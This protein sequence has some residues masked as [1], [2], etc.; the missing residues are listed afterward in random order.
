VSFK[1]KA[2]LTLIGMILIV[3]LGMLAG[4]GWLAQRAFNRAI[5]QNVGV[6]RSATLPDGI[7]VY[8]CGSGSPMPDADRAGPCL[9][10]LAGRDGFVFDAGA[11]SIR[12]LGRMGFPMDRLQGAYLTHLHSDHIDGLGELLLQAWIAGSRATPLPVS[13]P[14]GTEQVVAGLTQAYTIDSGYRI[15]HHGP[16]V[17]RPGGFGGVAQI[18]DL[19]EGQASKVV[20]DQ[21]GVKIT[22]IRV[23]HDP[24]KPAFGYRLDYKGRSIAISGDTVYAPDFVATAKGIDV[25]FHEALNPKMIGAMQAQL[26]KRGRADSAKVMADIPGYHASP[27]DAAR[28]AKEAGAKSLV[29]YHMV[30]A[31]P[32][33]L[34]ERLFVGDARKIY[35]GDLQLA[36]DGMI[37]HLTTGQQTVEFAEAF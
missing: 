3:G 32:A 2:G 27:E 10:V 15:A 8:V 23:I 9:A 13:G 14:A 18:L 1:R 5:E 20:Y 11:G 6:D 19:P 24:V 21:S 35:S 33:R 28:A 37:V 12:K 16:A 25:M 36:H 22:A 7:H 17:A 26:A 4:R 29:L 30:P 31:P 34:I